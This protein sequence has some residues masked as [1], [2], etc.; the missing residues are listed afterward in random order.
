MFIVLKD[1]SHILASLFENLY[2]RDV[3]SKDT[4]ENL[5]GSSEGSSNFHKKCMKE[6][7]KVG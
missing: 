3:L 1:V 4:I 5:T 6:L 7:S 2:T